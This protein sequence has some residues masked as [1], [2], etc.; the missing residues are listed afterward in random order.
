M[1]QHSLIMSTSKLLLPPNIEPEKVRLIA[2]CEA[3]PEKI[4]KSK[5][6]MVAEDIQNALQLLQFD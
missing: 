4:E 2:I 1:S 6:K 3:L 5:R